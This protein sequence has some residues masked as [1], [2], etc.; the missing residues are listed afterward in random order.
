M[1]FQVEAFDER[2][3]AVGDEERR[4]ARQ[5][6]EALARPRMTGTAGAAETEA[7]LRR[8]FEE[9]GYTV[10]ALPFSF[11]TW[12]GRFGVPLA[13]AIVIAGTVGATTL[14]TLRRPGAAAAVLGA[15]TILTGLGA[16]FSRRAIAGFPLSRTTTANWLIRRPNARPRRIVVAHRD[17]K[18]QP[19]STYL[20]TTGIALS[21]FSTV[22]LLVLAGIGALER[23]WIS[24][25]LT[26]GVG[27][28]G[29]IGGGLLAA[30]VAKNESP[31]ALDNASGLAALL[32]IARREQESEDVAFLV[33]DGE[34]LGLAGAADAA[35]RL[36]P[37][38]GVINLDG[39]DDDG[40]FR[41]ADR[42][43][44][45]RRRGGL[46][47]HLVAAFLASAGA[48]GLSIDRRDLPPGVLVDHIPFARAGYPAL[49]LLRGTARS[50]RRVHRP[51]DAPDQL[52][53]EGAALAVALVS[54]ALEWLRAAGTRA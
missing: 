2:V 16:L 20:R 24:V 1:E 18:S 33:T 21:G 47:P 13:G 49:T 35:R 52:T 12:P 22:A 42:F 8:R 38:D 4:A 36:P 19:V 15:A 7:E 27:T 3:R 17:T 46:A 39:L 53:G 32:G 5:A 34:E 10:E 28:L 30:C 41:L 31:G 43:G 50:L 48:L 40:E 26:I 9:L 6:V 44:W 23:T 29:L 45:P 11:S 14:L 51:E 54:G 25:P 37:L